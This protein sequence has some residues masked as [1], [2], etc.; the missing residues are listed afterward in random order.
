MQ[1]R[2]SPRANT[3]LGALIN[4]YYT[5]L[6]LKKMYRKFADIRNEA[7]TASSTVIGVRLALTSVLPSAVGFSFAN[8]S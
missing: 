3:I 2:S 7:S 6:L 5:V 8:M 4:T 1:L